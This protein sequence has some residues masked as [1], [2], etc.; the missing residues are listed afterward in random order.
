M[1]AGEQRGGDG[2]GAIGGDIRLRVGMALGFLAIKRAG[3]TVC[4]L[5]LF[6]TN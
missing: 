4:V 6:A 3:M 5:F 2:Y 1:R